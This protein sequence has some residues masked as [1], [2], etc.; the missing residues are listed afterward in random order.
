MT[1]KRRRWLVGLGVL[2]L[3]ILGL[4]ACLTAGPVRAQFDILGTAKEVLG[5][6]GGGGSSSSGLTDEEIGGGL[7][8]ALRVGTERAVGQVGSLDGYNLDPDIHIPLP[9]ALQDVQSVLKTVGMSSLADDL[10]VRLNRAA[11]MA[12]PEAKQ[13]FSDA[14]TDMTLEDV[15]AI[16]NGPDDAA[17]RYFKDK[18]TPSLAQR[19]EPIVDASLADVGAIQS[20]DTM[21]AQYA[22]IPF[23]PDAKADLNSYVVQQAMDGIFYYV[24]KEEAAIRNDPAARTTELLQSVFGAS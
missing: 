1:A 14:I 21:M 5:G 18:M 13:L 17:T 19:M 7:R 20:L 4:G 16:Y 8:E 3:G 10:E 22:T 15:Q 24:A 9:G 23:A 2:G 12:A 6:L 11:E